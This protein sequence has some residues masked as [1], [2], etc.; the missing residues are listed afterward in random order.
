MSL[1]QVIGL[2]GQS[3]LLEEG[4]LVLLSDK[5]VEL[6]YTVEAVDLADN[7]FVGEAEI[8]AANKREAY[9]NPWEAA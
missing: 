9:S 7:G 2:N 1:Y 4:D 8:H 3:V 5:I 6:G